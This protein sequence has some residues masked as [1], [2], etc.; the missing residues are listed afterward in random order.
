M[1]TVVKVIGIL[2]AR[3]GKAEELKALLGGMVVPSRGEPG[4]LQYNLWLVTE[5]TDVSTH[6][7]GYARTPGI[8]TEA[9]VEGWRLVTDEVHRN[10]GTIFSQI[11]TWAEW[12]TPQ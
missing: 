3:P 7:K 9:Q 1:S 12:L 11:C 8:Y 10:G 6:S 5:A 4:N 2:V